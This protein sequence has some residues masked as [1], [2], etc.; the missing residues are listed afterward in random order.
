[1]RLAYR[2]HEDV[3][4]VAL[5]DETGSERVGSVYVSDAQ[6]AAKLGRPAVS[7]AERDAFLARVPVHDA[8]AGGFAVG[9]VVLLGVPA[10]PRFALAISFPGAHGRL[11]LAAD[12]ALGRVAD[13]L[14]AL[15]AADTQ[16]VLVDRKQRAVTDGLSPVTIPG[17]GKSAQVATVGALLEAYAPAGQAGLGVLVTQPEH[18]AFAHVEDLRRRTLF[19]LAI[20]ALMA[21]VVG[22][23]LARDVSRRV[24][25]LSAGTVALAGG[26]PVPPLAQDGGDE[27]A[28]LAGAFNTMAGEIRRQNDEITRWNRELEERVEEK[29]RELKQAQEMLLRAR[30]LA[31]IG[32]LGAGVAHEINNPLTGVLGSAQLLLMDTPESAQGYALLKD[33]ETQAQRIRHIVANLLRVAQMESGDELVPVDLNRVVDDALTLVGTDSLS[34]ARI[35]LTTDLVPVPPVRANPVLLQE[36]VIE[37][38]TNA[39]KAMPSGG[40]ITL[41][42]SASDRRIVSLRVSDTGRGIEPELLDKIFDPF[43][44]TKEDWRATGMGLTMVHKIVSEHKGTIAVS[45]Q[46]G[47][48]ATFTLSFPSD[49]GRVH[50]E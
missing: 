38:V 31:A 49:G 42:T 45:S 4:V 20:A 12:V 29:S 19:W 34:S 47:A 26:Q 9:D 14:A 7:D 27:L 37:L 8:L 2:A 3:A 16:V 18:T 21:L 11:V 24:G 48:G 25:K 6:A 5:L 35:E 40:R 28:E 43:F 23:G 50:L 36:A 33:I 13:K 39:R 22:V 46:V 41:A 1:L 17:D 32:T 15:R 30:S 44:T 10:T